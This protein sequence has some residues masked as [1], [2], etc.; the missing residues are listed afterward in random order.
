MCGASFFVFAPG[1]PGPV[2]NGG[3]RRPCVR[4]RGS[5]AFQHQWLGSPDPAS[6]GTG[7]GTP[8]P[9]LVKANSSFPAPGPLGGGGTLA[10][11]LENFNLS[12][13]GCLP[14]TVGA[15]GEGRAAGRVS[16]LQSSAN[17]DLEATP[18]QGGNTEHP[19]LTSSARGCGPCPCQHEPVTS[20]MCRTRSGA[21]APVEQ[22]ASRAGVLSSKGMEVGA[23]F[24]EYGYRPGLPR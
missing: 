9:V 21:G 22:L 20:S 23:H 12:A 17:L 14:V 5:V 4:L 1:G 10:Q 13:A 15:A 2:F 11:S 18:Q 3:P 24:S 8:P 7:E 19:G 16:R 6:S